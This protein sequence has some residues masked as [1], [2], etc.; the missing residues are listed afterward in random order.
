MESLGV[1]N[2]Q[3]TRRDCS[4]RITLL[5]SRIDARVYRR[6]FFNYHSNQYTTGDV[7][8]DRPEAEGVY[9]S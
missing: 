5:S 2:E 1:A 9:F 8:Y 4:N 3:K 7:K 6:A